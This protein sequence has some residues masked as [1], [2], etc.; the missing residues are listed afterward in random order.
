M[1]LR[2]LPKISSDAKHTRYQRAKL[3]SSIFV[4]RVRDVI[5]SSRKTQ[6]VE[7]SDPLLRKG[8]YRRVSIQSEVLGFD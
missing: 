4:L 8:V 1:L 7:P 5:R 2:V 6:V 3:V